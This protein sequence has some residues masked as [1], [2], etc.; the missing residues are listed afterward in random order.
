LVEVEE[1]SAPSAI[2]EDSGAKTVALQ[3][4]DICGGEVKIHAELLNPVESGRSDCVS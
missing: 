2:H 3:E 1:H 4:L